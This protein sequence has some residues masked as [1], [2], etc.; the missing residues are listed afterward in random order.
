MVKMHNLRRTK[1][2]VDAEK[3]ALGADRKGEAATHAYVPPEDEGARVE[4]EHHH[5]EKMGLGG[6]LK[7]GDEMEFHGKG[8]VERS[9]TKSAP[10]GDRHSATIRFHHGGVD[11]EFKSGDG[12]ER[13]ALRSDLEKAHGK[14]EEK[15]S[16]VRNDK[17]I[18][19][20]A[21]K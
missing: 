1:A 13:N 20:K 17:K 12:E 6:K 18:P 15:A 14:A 11:G 9:E 3:K 2:D 7:S 16:S 4:F 21:G 8:T 5:L 19:E 10:E